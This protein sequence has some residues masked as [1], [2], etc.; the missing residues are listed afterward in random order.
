MA[1]MDLNIDNYSTTD[2]EN[3]FKVRPKKYS[4][5]DIDKREYEIRE[6]LLS[7]GHINKK[8]KRELVEF[9]K[10]AKDRLI[11]RLPQIPQPTSIAKNAILDT[12]QIPRSAEL[13]TSRAPLIIERPP[14]NYINIQTSEFYQ[15]TMNPL[16][17]R[18]ITK[19]ITIDTRFRDRYYETCSSDFMINL[20]TRMNKVV[21]MQLTSLELPTDFYSISSNYGNNYFVM[22]VFQMVDGVGYE[23]DRIIVVPDG[24]YT[25]KGLIGKINEIL[26]PRLSNGLL[27][28]VDDVF[29][30]IQ[31]SLITSE[32]GS[33]PN[34]VVVQPNPSYPK[35]TS[36]IEEIVLNFGTDIFGNNDTKYLT[37]KIGWNLGFTNTLYHG[38][39]EYTG[40]KAV[41][42]NSIKYIYLSVD[43][44]NKSVNTTF[45][46]A[47]EKNGLK[48]NILAR[49][50]MQGRGYENVIINKEYEI[51]SEPR[52]YFG[53]VDIQR[54]HIN[55]FD[56]HGR[57]LNLHKS[58]F[59]FCL[60][61]TVL[62]DL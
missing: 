19:Y 34:K 39:F 51:I 36:Q 47:F 28:Y 31:F 14:T 46:T 33:G 7:S 12:D 59:S 53:P 32:D 24:N 44:Y 48:P 40:E 2:L 50:T 20:P 16:N 61:L 45:M 30:Y 26:C 37:T 58:D 54:L 11:Q 1:E 42:P 49:I 3:F 8:F 25:A 4:F 15:G 27:Q 52:I 62:Y 23:T 57:T 43:D 21:S 60:K 41:E 10:Q 18:T 29:S 17:K 35:I 6:Q 38:K 56:D 22:Q 5:T 55:L 9:L 13:A